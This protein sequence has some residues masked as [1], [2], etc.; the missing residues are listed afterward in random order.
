MGEAMRLF[1]V[2]RRKKLPDPFQRGLFPLPPPLLAS[3]YKCFGIGRQIFMDEC[4]VQESNGV[5]T[6]IFM[7]ST[8]GEILLR[9]PEETQVVP[10]CILCLCAARTEITSG[11]VD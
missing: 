4:G 3:V 7:F 9:P 8:C 6:T 1:G 2:L 11:E 10:I 5:Q